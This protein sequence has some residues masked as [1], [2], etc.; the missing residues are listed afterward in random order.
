M[1]VG[2][3]GL[4]GAALTAEKNMLRANRRRKGEFTGRLLCSVQNVDIGNMSRSHGSSRV[5]PPLLQQKE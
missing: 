1:T 2:L 3:G 4:S 5:S